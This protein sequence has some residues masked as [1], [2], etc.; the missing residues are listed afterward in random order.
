MNKTEKRKELKK[1]FNKVKRHLLKQ[2]QR[3]QIPDGGCRYKT[4]DGLKC[5]VGCLIKSS[6]YDFKIEGLSLRGLRV[7]RGRWSSEFQ[8][9]VAKVLNNSG[10][11]AFQEMKYLLN[12][13]QYIHDE[14]DPQYWSEELEK[15]GS[16]LGSDL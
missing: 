14:T 7:V 3:A 6:A 4:A 13:L 10:I 8:N 15:L 9:S 12:N 1:Y 2:N 11:P 5:A 16:K